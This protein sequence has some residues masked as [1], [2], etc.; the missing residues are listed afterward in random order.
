M[1]KLKEFKLNRKKRLRA[2]RIKKLKS[3]IA[4]YLKKDFGVE[5]N[6]KLWTT[7]G[8]RFLASERNQKANNLY[9]RTI[10]YLSAYLI[11]VNLINIFNIPFIDE[12]SMNQIGFVTTSLSILILIYSQFEN[13]Q[14]YSIKSDKFHQC[15]LE[16]GE[17]YSELRMVKTFKNME[18]TEKQIKQISDKYDI[19]LKKYDNHLPIDLLLFKTTNSAYFELCTFDIFWI[20]IKRYFSVEL[21]YHSMIYGPLL[22]FICYQIFG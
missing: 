15:G 20:K 12:L 22:F 16:I 8:A 5:L 13:A 21:K 4:P 9:V 19:L 2:K 7:K 17:L 11:I 18:D 3:K 14:N 1:N 6:Y 10:G